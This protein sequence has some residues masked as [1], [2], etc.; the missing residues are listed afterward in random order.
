MEC[1]HADKEFVSA[2]LSVLYISLLRAVDVRMSKHA[3]VLAILTGLATGLDSIVST[4]TFEICVGAAT[5]S[6]PMASF[7]F[8][9]H[10][11]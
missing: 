4:C 8:T 3:I 1:V 10:Y 7:E 2:A 5:Q 11:Q 6:W 9:A